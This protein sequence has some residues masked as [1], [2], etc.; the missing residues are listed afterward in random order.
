[1]TRTALV[2]KAATAPD[3]GAAFLDFMLSPAGQKVLAEKVG[4]PALNPRVDGE[5][6]ASRMHKVYGDR[7]RPIPVGPALVVYLDQVKRQRLIER[8]NEALRLQ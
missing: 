2:P 6:T 1:M 8:W 5:N 7:L 4:L 3:L